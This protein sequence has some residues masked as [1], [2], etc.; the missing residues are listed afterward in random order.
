MVSVSRLISE[1]FNEWVEDKAQRLGAALAYYAA[2]S[3]APLLIIVVA[4][5]DFLYK[6]L[7]SRIF[8]TRL[9]Q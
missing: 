8:R 2:F 9:Q 4:V 1:T 7:R 5:V 3:M 6:E